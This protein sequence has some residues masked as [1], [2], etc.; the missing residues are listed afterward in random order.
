[1]R[2]CSPSGADRRKV[3]QGER[4]ALRV[5]I[6][7][8]G[9]TFDPPHLGHLALLK[10]AVEALDPDLAL[11]MPAGTPPHK[12]AYGTPGELRYQMCA[13]FLEV[14]PRV[15]RCRFELDHPGKSYTATTVEYLRWRWPG[16]EIDLVMGGD[17]LL[18][19]STWHRSDWLLGQIRLV[20]QSRDEAETARL[21]P[22]ARQLEERGGRVLFLKAPVVEL[23]STEVRR[24]CAE[25]RPIERMV[26]PKALRVIRKHHLYLTGKGEPITKKEVTAEYC[27][28]LAKRNLSAKRYQHTLNV[29]KLALKL[30]KQYGADEKKVE[31]AALLHDICK[32][33]PKSE[34]L[35]MLRDN[36]IMTQNAAEKPQSVWHA[37]AG[38]VYAATELGIEDPEILDAIA[39][40]TSARPG[41]TP[42]DKV[43]YMADMCSEDRSYPEVEELRKLLKKD[44]DKALI[45]ALQYSL[46]WL[47][48]EH[49][50]IDEDSKLALRELERQYYHTQDA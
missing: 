37:A 15:H 41:M 31:I 33:R 39:C 12:Q 8:F 49:K 9:G 24:A 14:D 7:L 1:M 36:A 18:S 45:R 10:N 2:R 5:K 16:C 20:V 46:Q 32:E 48:E 11:V 6:L 22:A 29:R 42:V 43:L 13:A 35:Q 28:K 26:P 3:G 47:K 23:S 27:K 17:M 4:E 44:L 19:F 21:A 38:M 40:H 50:Q 34:L 30:A 25:G